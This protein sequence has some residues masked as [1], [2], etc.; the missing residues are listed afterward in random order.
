MH[1]VL[2]RLHK[3]TTKISKFKNQGLFYVNIIIIIIR[4]VVK[5]FLDQQQDDTAAVSTELTYYMKVEENLQSYAAE[6]KLQSASL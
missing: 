4:N 1:V 2:D 6:L 3:Y 5:N